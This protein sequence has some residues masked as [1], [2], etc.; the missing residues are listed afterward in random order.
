[1][2]MKKSIHG[3]DRMFTDNRDRLE[4][5]CNVDANRDF[6]FNEMCEAYETVVLAYGASKARKMGLPNEDAPNCFSGKD[7]VSW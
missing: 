5:F 3:F 4:L 6:T 2:D 7:F 1:M